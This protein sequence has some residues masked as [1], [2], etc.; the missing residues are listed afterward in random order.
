[1]FLECSLLKVF[2]SKAEVA[3]RTGVS[4]HA[5]RNIAGKIENCESLD[6]RVDQGRHRIST[7]RG[8]RQLKRLSNKQCSAG[9]RNL[10]PDWSS[11]LDRE[12]S[13]RT[14]RRRLQS[15]RINSYVAKQKP[16]LT[17]N[18]IRK[19]RIWCTGKLSWDIRKWSRV[20]W[21]DESHFEL[22]K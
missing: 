21:S 16:F 7:P 6:N 5:V 12:A 20:V 14:V 18:Q 1:M 19:R 9:S 22:I 4:R 17:R 2:E 8:D 10:A 15:K 3:R 11:L 13:S